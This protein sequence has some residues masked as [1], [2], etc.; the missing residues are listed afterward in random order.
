MVY[1]DVGAT[2]VGSVLGTS[3]VTSFGESAAGM[4]AGAK[5]GLESVITAV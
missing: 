5:T 2:L 1:A 4:A 3:T